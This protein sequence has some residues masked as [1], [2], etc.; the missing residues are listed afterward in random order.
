MLYRPIVDD[1]QSALKQIIDDAD[2]T[3]A[4]IV[5]WMHVGG[6]RLKPQHLSKSRD[7]IY[8]SPF[9]CDVIKDGIDKYSVMPSPIYDLANDGGVSYVTYTRDFAV[10]NRNPMHSIPVTMTRIESARRL[11]YRDEERPSATNPYAY[12]LN[13]RIY[14]LGVENIPI[15]QVQLGI[16]TTFDPITSVNLDSEFRFPAHLLPILKQE[17]LN[18]GRMVLMTPENLRNDG[19]AAVENV[20]TQKQTGPITNE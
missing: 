10:G 15:T 2:I 16:F 18:M 4:Q 19:N 13:N 12:L 6:D 11:Y 20:P 5:Y 1:I 17:I 8:V 3:P 7:N 14:F 9:V